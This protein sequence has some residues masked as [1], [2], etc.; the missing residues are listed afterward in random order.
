MIEAIAVKFPDGVERDI[1]PLG[2]TEEAVELLDVQEQIASD[3]FQFSRLPKTFRR[4][5]VDSLR[6]SGY[7]DAEIDRATRSIPITCPVN[8]LRPMLMALFGIESDSAGG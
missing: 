7:E 1:S 8:V 2:L 4:C 5:L 3:G 6:A